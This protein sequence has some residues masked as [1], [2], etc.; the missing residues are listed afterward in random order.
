MTSHHGARVNQEIPKRLQAALMRIRGDHPFFGTLAL[1]AELRVTDDIDTAATDGRVLW[2]NAGFVE[3]LSVDQVCGLVTHELLHAALQHVYRRRERDRN[4]WNIA[5][6][7][8]VNGMIRNDTAYELPEGGVEVP[9]LA[10][11]SVEEIYEQFAAGKREAP[12]IELLDLLP[13]LSGGLGDTVPDHSPG[14][15][16]GSLEL[17]QAEQLE[18]HWR[19]ALQQAG[20]VAQR[21]NRGFGKHGLNGVREFDSATIPTL[22][23]RELLWQFMVATPYDFGGFDRRFI[24]RKLYLEDVIGESVEV[25]ICI[26]TSASI[27]DRE[28]S[29]FTAEVQGILDAYPQIRGTLFFADA[30]LHGPHDFNLAAG[31]PVAKGG[32]GTSFVPFFDWVHQ[33]ELSGSSPLCIYFTDG[34]GSFPA[35]PPASSVL[36]VVMPGGLETPGFPFG[37]VARMQEFAWQ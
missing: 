37:E 1:F 15:G 12:T 27:G 7:I 10:H 25:A 5:A 35:H 31:I 30:S 33:Q 17:T 2:F 16:H 21:I 4:L 14:S 29:A 24:H 6:D 22:G 19:A 8:V 23:W 11:L 26:D 36:W 34:F 20:A 9:T 28:L 32:G 18:R 13:E 3:K